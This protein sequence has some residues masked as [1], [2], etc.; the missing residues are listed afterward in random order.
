MNSWSFVIMWAA[1][2]AATVCPTSADEPVSIRSLLDEMADGD[3]LSRW[4]QP[5]YQQRQASSYNR[6]SIHGR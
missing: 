5:V 6:A 4:P 3:A 2:I 1:L